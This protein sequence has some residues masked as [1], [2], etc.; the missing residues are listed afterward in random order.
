MFGPLGAGSGSVKFTQLDWARRE[1]AFN[2]CPRFVHA[3]KAEQLGG[4]APSTRKGAIGRQTSTT[5]LIETFKTTGPSHWGGFR[6]EATITGCPS[7]FHA[8]KRLCQLSQHPSL[9]TRRPR[10][11][12]L[13]GSPFSIDIWIE[14][15]YLTKTNVSIT[16]LFWC[17]CLTDD[18]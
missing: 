4:A 12:P 9:P 13:P 5:K 11:L 14:A 16:R 7:I 17:A 10:S 8:V 15:G 18:V 3:L 2:V 6:I 1:I